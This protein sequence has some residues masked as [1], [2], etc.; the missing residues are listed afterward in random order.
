MAQ[1]VNTQTLTMLRTRPKRRESYGELVWRK[2]RRSKIAIIGGLI[3]TMLAVLAIFSDFF[4]PTDPTAVAMQGAY[5]PPQPI[6]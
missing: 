3:V 1:A 2:F 4:S 5:Q 6:P